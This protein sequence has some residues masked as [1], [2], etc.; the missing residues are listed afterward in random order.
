MN[1]E[2]IPSVVYDNYDDFQ[3]VNFLFSQN[4]HF[5]ILRIIFFNDETDLKGKAFK[6]I[7][8]TMARAAWDKCLSLTR[9]SHGE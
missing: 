8:W 3:H 2:I 4:F 5:T 7:Y 9:K 1:S 6:I